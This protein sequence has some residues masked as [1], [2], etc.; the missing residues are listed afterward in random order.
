MWSKCVVKLV[1]KLK[2]CWIGTKL[3][4]VMIMTK[5]Q[6]DK[7]TKR[8]QGKKTEIQKIHKRQKRQRRQRRQKRQG[9]N[10]PPD[11]RTMQF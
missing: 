4:F 1:V 11:S 2:N 8:Q 7:K 3:G 9:Q 6:K 10:G 5:R